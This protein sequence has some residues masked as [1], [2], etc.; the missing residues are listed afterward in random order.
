MRAAEVVA[1]AAVCVAVPL[2]ASK[3]PGEFLFTALW[4]IGVLGTVYYAWRARP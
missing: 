1:V 4:S 3:G 2:A